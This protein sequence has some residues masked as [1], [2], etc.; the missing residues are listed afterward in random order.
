MTK[1]CPDCGHESKNM[2]RCEN[3]GADFTKELLDPKSE[4]TVTQTEESTEFAETD[5]VLERN[6]EIE[7]DDYREMT[8]G[9]V[10]GI[11]GEKHGEDPDNPIPEIMKEEEIEAV[12]TTESAETLEET[13]ATSTDE[14]PT[15]DTSALDAYIRAHR[16]SVDTKQIEELFKQPSESDDSPLERESVI[17]TETFS[18]ET[19]EDTLLEEEVSDLLD[20]QLIS[21]EST[22]AVVESEP[23]AEAVESAAL[24]VEEPVEDDQ[25]NLLDEADVHED[26]QVDEL[27]EEP[28]ATDEGLI[29]ETPLLTTRSELEAHKPKKSYK[30]LY[31]SLAAI[32]FLGAGGYGVYAYQQNAAR[33][34]AALIAKQKNEAR[35]LQ[36][37]IDA[38][39]LDDEHEFLKADM[40]DLSTDTLA[41]DLSALSEA[42][43]YQ[44]LQTAL[45][46]LTEKQAA[47][48]SVND[49]FETPIIAGDALA[50]DA[51]LKSDQAPGVARFSDEDAL[52]QLLNQGIDEAEV[53]FKQVQTARTALAVVFKDDKVVEAATRSQ[54]QTAKDEAAKVKNPS[55]K[56]TLEADLEKVAQALAEKEAEAKAKKEAEEKAAAEEA[57]RQAAEEAQ[58]TPAT[59]APVN[60]TTIPVIEQQRAL[61]IKAYNQASINDASNPAWNWAPGVLE[62]VIQTCIDRGYIVEGGYMLEKVTIENGEGYYNLFA[63]SNQSSLFKNYQ[64]N[65]LPIYLVTINDKTGWFKGNGSR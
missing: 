58:A 53:Q 22:E 13:A 30:K 59:D 8:L 62:K 40:V 56:K 57:A 60:Q 7:W 61:S 25:E 12:E 9:N 17:D 6:D 48:Q 51:V 34:Q 15:V 64:E 52:D 45:T 65:Q 24:P 23:T 29:E 44:S 32:A 63:T 20:D 43:Q 18:V 36:A 1:K 4:E 37:R 49:L 21:E 11:L 50:K 10:M 54:Y 41:K 16:K 35:E 38:Y 27:E 39:Y 31:I 26:L 19:S 55:F 33:E 2:D 3:C 14:L 42:S 47:I 46:T 28:E 5:K